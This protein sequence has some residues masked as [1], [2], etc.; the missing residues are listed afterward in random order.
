[1][2]LQLLPPAGLS[3]QEAGKKIRFAACATD[4]VAELQTLHLASGGN[5]AAKAATWLDIP[6]NVFTLS[7]PIEYEGPR[8]LNFLAAAT[9]EAKPVA[10]IE[11]PGDARSYLLVFVPNAE[12]SGYRVLPIVDADIPYGSYFLVNCSMFQV[13]VN[14]DNQKKVLPPGGK[15]SFAGANGQPQDVRIHASIHE[16]ARLLRS[17]RWQLDANQREVVL[18]YGQPGSDLVRSKHFMA[19]RATETS[20]K[21]T[22][23]S[24]P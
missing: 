7:Q 17:T 14:I 12:S 18:F 13:A 22:S 6:L 3:A 15:A 19:M 21:R 4:I 16:Q 24:P 9:A 5:S 11:L 1:M 2:S 10:S 8:T 23:P 20:P